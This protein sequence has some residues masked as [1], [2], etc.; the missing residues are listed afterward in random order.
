MWKRLRSY[1]KWADDA[2]DSRD[3]LDWC[4]L[5]EQHRA[6]IC[7]FQHERMVHLLVTLTTFV[8]TLAILGMAYLLQQALLFLAVPLGLVLSF[9]YMV[10]YYHLEN[11]VQKL[12]AQYDEI[13]RRL[14]PQIWSG[15]CTN[16]P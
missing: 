14:Y 6:Q 1:L 10:H 13:L 11:G 2:L 15:T 4:V 7:F 12:Y 16:R 3:P 9:A 5:L 8:L